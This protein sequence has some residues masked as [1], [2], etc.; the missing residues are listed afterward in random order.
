MSSSNVSLTD[1]SLSDKD[2][3]PR[4][5][6]LVKLGSDHGSGPTG[7]DAFAEVLMC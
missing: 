1:M 2:Q 7:F 3:G 5:W 6:F 4:L